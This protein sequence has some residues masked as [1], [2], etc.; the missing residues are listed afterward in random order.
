T[1]FDVSSREG[2]RRSIYRFIVRS[3][4]DPFMDTLDCPDPSILTPTRN[5]TLTALQALALLN[6]PLV[7]T[8]ARHLALRLQSESPDLGAQVRRAYELARGRQPAPSEHDRVTAYA[9][10]HGL[11]GACRIL[12]N[13]NEFCFI[14]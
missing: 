9:A 3:V 1:R 6:N 14:D 8:E 12:F 11:A 10:R 2:A 13:S 5:E 4:P 7:L